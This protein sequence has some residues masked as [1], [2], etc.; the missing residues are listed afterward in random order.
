M[1]L[2]SQLYSHSP[3]AVQNVLVTAYGY[4][5]ARKRFGGRYEEILQEACK[6]RTLSVDRVSALQDERF[7]RLI[8]HVSTNVPYYQDLFGRVGLRHND[9]R[10]AQDLHKLPVLGRAEVHD[11]L[12]RLRAPRVR[13]HWTT[14]TSGSTG[15]PLTNVLDAYSYQLSMALLVCHEA[16]HGVGRNERRA[17]FAGRLVQPV[18]NDRA[19]FWRYNWA[20]HQLLCSVYHMS[21]RNLVAY[22]EA[23][24]DFAPA[25]IIGYPSAIHV[26]ADFCRRTKR[27]I[28]MPLKTVVTNSETLHDWQRD[29]IETSLGAPIYDYYSTAESILFAGQCARFRYHPEP[30]IGIWEALDERNNPVAPGQPGRLICTTLANFAMPL[31]RY[32]SGD[33]VIVSDRPC[34]CGRPGVVW[35]RVLG[36]TGDVVITP[37]G[38]PIGMLDHVFDGV[39]IRQAQVIQTSPDTL[40]LRVVPDV[41]YDARTVDTLVRKTQ[42]R[43][44]KT[45][46]ITVESVSSIERAPNGKFPGVIREF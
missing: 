24:E 12:A 16:E 8:E 36:R 11:N 44:G 45:M 40:V 41:G 15:P 27:K 21:D 22:V 14:E 2:G 28:Q 9:L 29:V 43:V 1:R 39:N 23:L 10:T 4:M 17:T 42:E 26:L 13:A 33:V 20:E 30:L 35:E 34:E 31:I 3:V 38:R 25:E 18:T 6:T 46:R 32:D 7:S 37:E 5:R 19:P